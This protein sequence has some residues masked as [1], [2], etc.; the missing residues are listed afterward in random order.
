MI[1][2]ASADEARDHYDSLISE[3]QRVVVECDVALSSLESAYEYIEGVLT[4]T[5]TGDLLP[6]ASSLEVDLFDRQMMISDRIGERE[7]MRLRAEIAVDDLESE[8]DVVVASVEEREE[9]EEQA[10][11]DGVDG[12]DAV[13]AEVDELLGVKYVDGDPSRVDNSHVE[14]IDE[15]EYA[16]QEMWLRYTD[17]LL[18][19]RYV[20][21][22]SGR[23]DNSHVV[24]LDD[25]EEWE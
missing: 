8:R 21:G 24:V 25:T 16:V 13:L 15:D 17:N 14:F 23:V 11:G 12:D 3:K 2:F 20:D 5:E 1:V 22:D 10:E 9:E 4:E 18:G 19:V 7:D 6:S